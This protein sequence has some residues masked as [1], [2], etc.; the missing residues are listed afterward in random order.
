MSSIA[1]PTPS[2]LFQDRKV[3]KAL[4]WFFLV[5]LIA[6]TA[7][8]VTLS[9]SGV[10]IGV[11]VQLLIGQPACMPSLLYFWETT[12]A[13]AKPKIGSYVVARMPKTQFT[14]GARPGDRIVKKVM[15]GPGD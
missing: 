6:L 1:A 10:R 13:D 2:P 3:I 11:D 5:D 7:F 9:L 15:A 8:V 12:A 4:G 14:I